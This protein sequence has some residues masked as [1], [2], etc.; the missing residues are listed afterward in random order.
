MPRTARASQA[1]FCYLIRS[2]A[3]DLDVGPVT[4]PAEWL[5]HVQQPQTE[6]EVEAL[7]VS[8]LRGRPFGETTWMAE[9]AARLGLEASLRPRGRPR[10]RNAGPPAAAP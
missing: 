2:G 5:S 4:R 7:R 3:P 1:G 10:K 8:F 6:A 9:T